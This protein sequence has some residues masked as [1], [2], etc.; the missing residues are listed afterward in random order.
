MVRLEERNLLAPVDRMDVDIETLPASA[1]PRI[2]GPADGAVYRQ[3]SA[4]R[5]PMAR[6]DRLHSLAATLVRQDAMTYYL[7][8]C[9]HARDCWFSLVQQTTIPAGS[10]CLD[11][12]II[13]SFRVLDSIIMSKKS[14]PI[15]SG[16][17]Y[18]QL[19]RLFDRLE[20]IVA[21]SR[22]RGLVHREAGYRNASIALDIYMTAQEECTDPA[23]RRRQLLERKRAGRRWK[24]LAGPS[25]L[26]LLVYSGAAP[27]I[28]YVIP[29][30][31]LSILTKWS[32][33]FSRFGDES[34]QEV[35]RY[36]QTQA[37]TSLV[38]SC[39]KLVTRQ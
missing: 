4:S 27:R 24:Q 22:Q 32:K 16:L 38:E 17:A 29:L 3:A 6:V 28:V 30:L 21:S 26:F 25:P 10:S 18:V 15:A 11:P 37:P 36:I 23:A 7:E 1:K 39:I 34:L 2:R 19:I 14:T 33:N 31:T 9:H 13:S 20:E 5:S 8:N 35:A 12:V